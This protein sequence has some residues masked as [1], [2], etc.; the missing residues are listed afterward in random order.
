IGPF[1]VAP[2]EVM[3]A[4]VRT[5]SRATDFDFLRRCAWEIGEQH[6]AASYHPPENH[7]GLGMV[8]PTEG[9]A[10]WRLVPE[11]VEQTAR[12]R[13]GAWD[14]SRMILRLYDVSHVHFNGLNAHRIQDHPLPLL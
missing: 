5:H 9:F 14:H 1:V 3:T 11:W 8:S 2:T 6:A 10:H 12:S 4:A 13:D 7:V